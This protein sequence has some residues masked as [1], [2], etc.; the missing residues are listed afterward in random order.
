MV[1]AT[2]HT[3]LQPWS[4]E[5]SSILQKSNPTVCS[6]GPATIY[7]TPRLA[8]AADDLSGIGDWVPSGPRWYEQAVL[9]QSKAPEHTPLPAGRRHP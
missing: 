2:P 1:E 6:S 3:V 9:S 7:E 8:F 4:V 5:H